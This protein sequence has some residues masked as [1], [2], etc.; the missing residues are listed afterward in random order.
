MNLSKIFDVKNLLQFFNKT[1]S[2]EN[3]K[4]VAPNKIKEEH[5][6]I[7]WEAVPAQ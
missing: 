4:N 2:S 3:L 5:S 1:K 7:D 6:D